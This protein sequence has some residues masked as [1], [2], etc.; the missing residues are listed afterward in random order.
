M[1]ADCFERHLLFRVALL[2]LPFILLG[3]VTISPFRRNFQGTS[4]GRNVLEFDVYHR[5][6]AQ[7]AMI[8][9]TAFLF[10]GGQLLS[11]PVDDGVLRHV[12]RGRKEVGRGGPGSLAQ[13]VHGGARYLRSG[14]RSCS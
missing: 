4:V 7:I 13:A 10:Q 5:L 2:R 8:V 12:Q 14:V 3:F 6:C 9:R 11:I 1:L